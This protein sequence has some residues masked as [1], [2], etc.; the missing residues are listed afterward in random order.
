MMMCISYRN[1][2]LYLLL[3]NILYKAVITIDA[4]QHEAGM[5]FY[6]FDLHTIILNI[7]HWTE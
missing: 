2:L 4:T 7:L 6:T 1:S 5:Y 3:E